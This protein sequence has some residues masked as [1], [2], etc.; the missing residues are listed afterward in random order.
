[1]FVLI[2]TAYLSRPEEVESATTNCGED[3]M[4][5]GFTIGPHSHDELERTVV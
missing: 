3:G 2:L 4:A 5:D 1:M